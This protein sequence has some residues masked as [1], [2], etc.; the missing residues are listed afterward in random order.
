MIP[1]RFVKLES[2]RAAANNAVILA[3]FVGR[4]TKWAKA[5]W[6]FIKAVLANTFLLPLFYTLG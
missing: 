2:G 6:S 5:C 1:V 3:V 4:F